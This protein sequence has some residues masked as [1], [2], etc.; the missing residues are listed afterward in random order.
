MTSEAPANGLERRLGLFPLTNIVIANMVGAGIFTTSGLLMKDLHHPVVM[1]GLWVIGGLIALCGA[2]SYGEL[3]AAFP[4]AGGE[5]AF[6][7]RLYHPILGFLS[8][9]VSFF[10]G[11]SAPIAA[12]AIGFSEY[13]TRAFPGLLHPGVIGGASEAVVMKKLYAILIIAAFTF[14]H[15]RGLETG[16]RVQNALTGLKILLIVGLVAAGF[17]VG[18]GSLGHLVA[19]A[20]F[21]FDFGGLKT[22]GLSLMWIMFAYSGWNASAY[23]GSEVK[24][25]SRNL[26]RSLLIG[27]GVV[28]LLYVALNLFYIY[29]IPPAQ[30]EGVISVGGLAAGNL[31]GKSAET[32][33]SALISFALFSSLSAYLILGPRVYYS[34]ARDGIFFKSIAYVDPK[35]SV[36]TRSIVLQGG[37]AAVMVLFGTFDQLLT[38]MGFSLGIFPLLA[39]LGVFK[40]RRTGR[41]AVKLPGYPVASAV[42]IFVGATI[43]VLAFLERPVE[44]LVAVATA[45]AGIPVYLFFKRSAGKGACPGAPS[46]PASFD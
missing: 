6:L 39:V 24:N 1:L 7:S 11:F 35:C 44:S 38:Y 28:M 45:L 42:Y 31:F 9:W 40:L 43:L 2:L 25:P 32:V 5:Y 14:L 22:L 13:L 30:M 37:I 20:P 10:V 15:T 8:G 17:A 12:S 4:H 46:R 3:G 18:K 19:A 26:P 29:A 33:L 34:M 41:S 23:I 21:R 27:T 16:T 36:P